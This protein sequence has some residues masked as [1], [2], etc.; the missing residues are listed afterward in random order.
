MELDEL[1]ECDKQLSNFA[2]FRELPKRAAEK[3]SGKSQVTPITS[4]LKVLDFILDARHLR[5]M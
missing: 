1:V 5:P 4:P 3:A 2:S